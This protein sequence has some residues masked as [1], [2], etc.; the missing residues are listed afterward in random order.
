MITTVWRS[1]E[2]MGRSSILP[3]SREW[4]SLLMLAIEVEG[5]VR[6]FRLRKL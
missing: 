1:L 4:V 3:L 5:R 2:G 6:L